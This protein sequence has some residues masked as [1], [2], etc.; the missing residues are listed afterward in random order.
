MRWLCGVWLCR[1]WTDLLL[2][3][4]KLGNYDIDRCT[5]CLFSYCMCI[6]YYIALYCILTHNSL[7]NKDDAK[8]KCTWLYGWHVNFT[9]KF[10][11]SHTGVHTDLFLHDSFN[12]ILFF[13]VFFLQISF[14]ILFFTNFFF[15]FKFFS[16]QLLCCNLF[17][18][19][20][21]MLFHLIKDFFCCNVF[22][23]CLLK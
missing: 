5:I 12:Y 8:K 1:L 18:W 2:M 11:V 10:T 17:H 9:V 13:G 21:L 19:Y 4:I 3:K 6:Q 16:I 20:I 23:T 15:S 22:D 7:E 14:F